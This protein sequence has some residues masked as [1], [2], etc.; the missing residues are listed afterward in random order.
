M[1]LERNTITYSDEYPWT[2]GHLLART[3]IHLVK[4]ATTRVDSHVTTPRLQTIDFADACA[5]A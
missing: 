3:C 2:L 4:E 5:A 1:L